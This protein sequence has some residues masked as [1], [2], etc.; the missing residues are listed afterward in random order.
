MDKT[1]QCFLV[2]D[3]IIAQ[4]LKKFRQR[5]R[6]VRLEQVIEQLDR[7]DRPGKMIL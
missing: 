2:G 4:S 6:L 3:D 5:I 7:T 1:F